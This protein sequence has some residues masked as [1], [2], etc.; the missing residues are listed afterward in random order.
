MTEPGPVQRDAPPARQG[1]SAGAPRLG[2]VG[3]GQLA[4]M[5]AQA[6][7]QLGVDVVI[8]ERV[9]ESP[10]ASAA[11]EVLIGDWSS[12]EY[13]Q[14]LASRVDVVT[15]ENEFVDAKLV[16]ALGASGAQV[17]P[18]AHTMGVVQDKLRAK[19]TLAREGIPVPAFRAVASPQDLLDAAEEWAWPLVLKRRRDGYDGRGNAT[20]RGAADVEG[21]WARLGGAPVYV[22]AFCPFTTELATIVTRSPDG[23][24]VVYPVVETVQRDH[25]CHTVTAP[26]S[27]PAAIA[28][29][30]AEL[31]K[32]AVSA[33][34]GTGSIGVEMFLLADGALLINELAPRV[35]NS[36]HYTIE[37]CDS[38]QFENHVRAVLRW[39]LGSP[40]MCAPAAAMVNLLGAG[41]GPGRPAGLDRALAVAGAHVHVYGKRTSTRGRKMGHVTALGPT[42]EAALA[43]VR[44]AARH[45]RF[46]GDD[47]THA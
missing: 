15:F 41:D 22:E 43:T 47:G 24:T 36:G 44:A 5:T 13:L 34:A 2:I 38:S 14:A 3:G 18:S 21:A 35:H 27:V 40:A 19:T 25:I 6:A 37:A 31:A 29:R 11:A 12:L 23:A 4:R 16:E 45:I 39:P 30:A 7:Q 10:A 42:P 46:G 17:W 20:V 8:L 33:V 26:A 28:A 9:S 32:R 1:F